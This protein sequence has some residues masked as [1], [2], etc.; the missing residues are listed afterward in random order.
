[1]Y[2]YEKGEKKGRRSVVEEGREGVCCHPRELFHKL[3]DN[4]HFCLQV[5]SR[6]LGVLV[7]FHVAAKM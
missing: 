7:H 5:F 6:F 4:P 1:M 2:E 3:L